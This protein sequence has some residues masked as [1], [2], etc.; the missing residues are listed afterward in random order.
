MTYTLIQGMRA[1]LCVGVAFIHVKIYLAH[2]GGD[3]SIFQYAPEFLG[4]APCGFFAIS[5]Y[6]MA[7]MVHRVTPNFLPQRAVRIYPMY[8]LA[9]AIAYGLRYFTGNPLNFKDLNFVL[10]LLPFGGHKDYKLGIEWTL[11]YEIFFYL[12][13]AFFCRPSMSR[14]FPKFLIAWLV[15][16]LVWTMLKPTL[17]INHLPDFL[18]IWT[19]GWTFNFVIGALVYYFLKF[20]QEPVVQAWAEKLVLASA[21]VAAAIQ[22]TQAS[23]IFIF[24]LGSCL[25]LVGL[26]KLESLIQAP[27]IIIDL[28]DYSYSLYLIH[29]TIIMVVIGRWEYFTGEKPGLIAGLFS[30]VLC[31]AAYWYLGQLDVAM[32]K[33]LKPWVSRVLAKSRP[34]GTARIFIP[35]PAAGEKTSPVGLKQSQ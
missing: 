7:T 18:S 1:L 10:P 4:A 16:V 2:F 20:Y 15:A 25:L 26:I 6:F 33:R 35:A 5:G 23:V 22:P 11:V 24:G 8:F 29:P 9:V 19:N 30:L 12:V 21:F 13:C 27:K 17:E 32:H 3:L 34:A 28:G 14:H 31:L